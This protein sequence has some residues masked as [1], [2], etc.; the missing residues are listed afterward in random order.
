MKTALVL[1][2]ET[3]VIETRSVAVGVTTTGG[4]LWPARFRVR[5]RWVDP[6]AA[7][8]WSG[9]P[10]ERTSPEVLRVLRGDFFCLP[11]GG[12]ATAHAGGRHPAHGET[13]NRRWKLAAN[14]SDTTLHFPM[15]SL[16]PMERPPPRGHRHR[17]DHRVFPP[18]P[19]RIG[20]AEHAQPRRHPYQH[21]P[22]PGSPA[23]SQLNHGCRADSP[24]LRR[25]DRHRGHSH[26]D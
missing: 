7:A 2:Q 20:Q 25:G 16:Q 23:S 10:L 13:A 24:R 3:R 19:C 8:P 11:F 4:H 21:S 6:L 18:R 26:R 9:E 5:D 12:N 14:S 1:G 22:R 17:G 15:T